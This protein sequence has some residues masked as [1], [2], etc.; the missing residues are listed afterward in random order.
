MA[1]SSTTTTTKKAAARRGARGDVADPALAPKGKARIAWAGG[2]MPVLAALAERFRAQRTFEGVR[3]SAC[4]HVTSETANLVKAL[5]A[6]GAE[7][8]LCASN[9]LSTQDDVAASLLVD[10][11][12]EVHAVRGEDRDRY[13]AHIDAALAHQPHVTIDDGADLVSRLHETGKAGGK[14]VWGSLEETTTGV[15]RLRSMARDGALKIPVFAVNDAQCKHLF[16]NRYG[17][18]QST[19]DGI[20]RATNV[21]L[22]GRTVVVAG[23]GWCGK[24]VAMRARGLGAHVVVTEIDPVKAIEAALDGH[25]VMPMAEAAKVGDVFVTVTGNRDVVR[26][27]HF[28]AMKD[29][30]IVCNSGHFD[31]EVDVKGLTAAATKIERDV[32]SGVDAFVL[33]GGKR[34]HLLAEGRLVNLAAAEGHP[35]SVMDMSFSV[36]AL[37]AAFVVERRGALEP[38]VHTVP[39][40]VDVEVA[41]LKLATMGLSIDT[42]TKVQ[43]RYLASW[44]EGT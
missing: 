17:T 13:W 39:P 10:E 44:R 29:G 22:A 26:R 43:E 25:R 37:T 12:V 2:Q 19:I 24:G 42:L 41:A 36:Q 4:L 35:A 7:V 30:A 40:A 3:L 5:V 31:V 27:E 23:Y 18:G 21:L 9:P 34:V 16:D 8:V 1:K 32:R 15:I 6:G 14:D 28:A 20:V 33:K 11:G 38:V